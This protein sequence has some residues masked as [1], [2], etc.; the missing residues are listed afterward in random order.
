M[1]RFALIILAALLVALPVAALMVSVWPRARHGAAPRD[2]SRAPDWL[3]DLA[4][5]EPG[6]W[7]P[8]TEIV[9]HHSAGEL[10]GL[11]SIDR[12]H[13][14]GRHWD[15]AGYD[16]IIGN[17]SFSGDG[18]I[19]VSSRWDSQSDGAHCLY[20]NATAIGICLVG[21]FDV[22][23]EQPSPFQIRS[24]VQLV[25]YLAVRYNIPPERIY[26]HR[27]IPEAQTACPGRNFPLDNIR[28]LV[29]KLRKEYAPAPL[30][31]LLTF[32][33]PSR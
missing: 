29:E 33:A 21:N 27:D 14:S 15:S 13:R 5:V 9:V 7:R 4:R 12:Y 31:P 26:V 23:D 8:W 25:A 28:R 32:P 22:H 20:H 18:E 24:L 10:G 1:R 17:G 19:E 16:F 3:K 6:L 2:T 11:E 30:P